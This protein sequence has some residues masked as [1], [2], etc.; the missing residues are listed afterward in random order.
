MARRKLVI[1]A[2]EQQ[3]EDLQNSLGI[4]APLQIALQRAG[5]SVH[6]YY[7]W[8]AIASIAKA[9]KIEEEVNQLEALAKSGVPL[10]EIREMADAACKGKKTGVGIYIEPSA[11]SLL[12]YRNSRKFREFADQCYEII[13]TC[14][15]RRGDFATVQLSRISKSTDK[16]EKINPSGAMWWLERNL[17]D[18]FAKP[19][20]KAKDQEVET[21]VAA[22]PSIKV[23]FVD[24]T[25]K[26]QQQ[27]LLDMENEILNDQKGGKA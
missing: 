17:P 16:K 12:R 13:N 26:E 7:Y 6:T 10:S 11:E 1:T 27:R 15:K 19:S 8:V 22:V 23:E 14:D 2:T 18:Y 24:P 4:G 20:D 9:A 21:E 3:I 25:T 5:I